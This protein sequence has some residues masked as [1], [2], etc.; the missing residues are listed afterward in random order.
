MKIN[1]LKLKRISKIKIKRLKLY[2]IGKA[3]IPTQK[4]RVIRREQEVANL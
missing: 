4:E 3:K 2:K 1:K